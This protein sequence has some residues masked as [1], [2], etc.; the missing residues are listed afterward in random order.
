MILLNLSHPLTTRQRY[1]IEATR[2]LEIGRIIEERVHLDQTQPFAPQIA[3]FLDALSTKHE[4][5][6]AEWQA[7]RILLVP[8]GHAPAT[9]VLLAE[10]HGRC[11]HFPELVRIRPA[12]STVAEPYQIAEIIPLQTIRDT[13][14]ERN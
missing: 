12:D 6:S 14:R 11:G 1:D 2:G 3:T 5:S 8:P 13:A 4:L 9:A 7:K 10:L